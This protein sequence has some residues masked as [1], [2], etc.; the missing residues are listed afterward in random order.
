MSDFM[1]DTAD[2]GAAISRWTD[3]KPV[4]RDTFEKINTLVQKYG[5]ERSKLFEEMLHRLG[6]PDTESLVDNWESLCDKGL[7]L[8]ETFQNQ[9]TSL[10][11]SQADPKIVDSSVSRLEEIGA[12]DFAN[13]D[14]SIWQENKKA[15]VAYMAYAIRQIHLGDIELRQKLTEDL[16]KTR[17]DSEVANRALVHAFGSSADQTL[18]IASMLAAAGAGKIPVVG[19]K[20]KDAIGILKQYNTELEAG[21]DKAACKKAL[22]DNIKLVDGVGDRLN[23]TAV[24]EKCRDGVDAATSLSVSRGNY[25]AEDWK[26]FGAACKSSLE[27]RRDLCLEIAKVIFGDLR[28]EYVHA[29][30]YEFATVLT[31][32]SSYE[33]WKAKLNDNAEKIYNELRKE[34]EVIAA[35]NNN[36]FKTTAYQML[37]EISEAVTQEINRRKDATALLEEQMRS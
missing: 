4:S 9:A 11:N 21:K 10:I 5:D 13:G 27:E 24:T 8:M 22:L 12:G 18:S 1:H 32:A 15:K 20:I 36:A 35:M 28:A 16:K 33:G 34:G 31:D 6:E 14:K 7:S 19:S 26:I 2:L 23:P 17:E 25:R 30:A 29:T 37:K 3:D